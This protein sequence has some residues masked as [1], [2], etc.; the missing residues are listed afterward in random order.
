MS[1]PRPR[2]LYVDY[3]PSP[4]M[5]ASIKKWEDAVDEAERLRHEARKAIAEELRT[6][7][8]KRDGEEYPISHAAVAQHVPWSEPTVL[9]I[10]REYK[11]PGVRQRKKAADDA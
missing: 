3:K 9:T 8:V 5:L 4:E 2:D 6:A 1:R 10:A 11:V 7:T